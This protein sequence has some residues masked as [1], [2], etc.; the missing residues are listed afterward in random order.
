MKS[1]TSTKLLA[2]MLATLVIGVSAASAATTLPSSQNFAGIEYLSGGIG[3]DEVQ[4][5]KGVERNWPLTLEFA[6]KDK[7]RA[8][9]AA[10]VKVLIRN[11]KG[12]AVL[13]ASGV[14]PLLL[15]RLTP[16]HYSVEAHFAGKTMLQKVEVIEGHPTKAVILW[17]AGTGESTPERKAQ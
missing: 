5:I 16:G 2:T 12:H 6:T 15:A 4:A 11:D 9:F 17:P 1:T 3:Q 14:G 13:E 8:T 7:S 10:N